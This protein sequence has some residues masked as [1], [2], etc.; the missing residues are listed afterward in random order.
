MYDY[1]V[2]TQ[3]FV[4]ILEIIE[5][6]LLSLMADHISSSRNVL[7]FKECD[8]EMPQIDVVKKSGCK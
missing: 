3:L 4:S 6:C 8:V 7:F 5:N 1:A 2:H